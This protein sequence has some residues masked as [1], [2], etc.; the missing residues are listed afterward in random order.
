M[1]EPVRVPVG[2]CRCKGAPHTEDAVFLE[3]TLTNA[4]GIAGMAVIREGTSVAQVE[5]GLAQVYLTMGIRGWTFVDEERSGVPV[6]PEAIERL[7][8]FADGGLVVSEKADELYSAELMRPLVARQSRPSPPT[9]TD[10]LTSPTFAPVSS[11]QKHSKRSSR[12][13]SAGKQSVVP[14]P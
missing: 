2:P 5:G 9:S 8:P 13:G 12:N 7:L 3:P 14:V 10:V 4:M 6:T 1:N 11:R